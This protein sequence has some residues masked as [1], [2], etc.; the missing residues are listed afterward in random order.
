[1]VSDY[2][3]LWAPWERTFRCGHHGF[4]RSSLD[5]QRFPDLLTKTL[6]E[7][8]VLRARLCIGGLQRRGRS[9]RADLPG[10]AELE[11]KL[12]RRGSSS[13]PRAAHRGGA[14]RLR[15]L[16]RPGPDLSTE[17]RNKVKKVARQLL[18]RLNDVL[19]LDW[20]KTA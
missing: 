6:C 5:L 11:P 16:P 9:D 2:S 8:T 3:A 7:W 15:L 19:S 1:M 14:R 17:E 18:A 12:H 10:P 4:P 13:R 20:H